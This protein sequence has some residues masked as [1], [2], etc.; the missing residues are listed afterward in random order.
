MVLL[1]A[2]T[3]SV[4]IPLK[5]IGTTLL[6]LGSALG[7]VVWIFQD[8]HLAG[9]LG[10]Q[11]VGALNAPMPPIIIAIA[12]G[13]AMDYEIFI[14]G[15]MRESWLR[16]GDARTSVVTALSKTGKVVTCA[17]LMLMVVFA[18]FMTGG[19]APVLQV[20]LGLTLAV[21]IDAT[22]VRMLLVPAT[23]A[24]MGRRAWWAPAPL[25]RLHDRFGLREETAP[26]APETDLGLVGSHR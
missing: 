20:G 21:L 13:L 25:R 14:L 3:G 18:C 22:I 7:I 4:L 16:T 11:G 23:M 5:T 6:S 10:T 2:F 15:R 19:F 9:L 12:F 8:G 24:L 1:F 26:V 17:A